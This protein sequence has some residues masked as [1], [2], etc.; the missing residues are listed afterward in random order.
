M[1]QWIQDRGQWA[2][3]AAFLLILFVGQSW[4]TY[5]TFTSQ[6]PGGNDFAARWFNGCA[7]IWAGE[8]P[9]SDK[10]TVQTQVHMYGRPAASGEDLVAFSYPIYALYFFWPLCFVQPYTLV[11]AIWTT[12]MLYSTIAGTLLMMRVSNL[13][14]TGGLLVITLIWAVINYPEARAVLLGQMVIL[15]FVAVGLALWALQRH[16]DLWAGVAL[17]AATI[18]PQVVFL[19]VLWLLWWSAWQ[20]RWRLWWG[21][22]LTMVLMGCAGFLLVP[23][24]PMDY[25]RHL[26]NY[27]DVTISPYYSLTWMIVQHFLNLGP[28]VEIVV[29]SLLALYLLS[30][31]WQFRRATGDAMLWATGLTLNLTFFVA[32][33]IA[34][35]AYI[36]LLLPIFQL[37][38]LVQLR[39]SWP[40]T[41][42]IL[43]VEGVLFVS[44]WGIFLATVQERFETAPAYLF[45]PIS[46]LAFQVAT[47]FQL[48]EEYPR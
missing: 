19:L 43:T 35:T 16:A 14:L 31:W 8:N 39:A 41:G 24:W 22:G 47:R 1:R 44:Q 37:L 6:F 21:F 30:Q 46:L 45:L 7:L 13:R 9:Y 42:I 25:A 4:V 28:A 26:S 15:V 29:S 5:H 20:K 3:L 11:Q 18:K 34:T 32:V 48:V 33:Q 2:F 38:R 40:A 12:L 23:S 27:A 17:A 10:V 36:L